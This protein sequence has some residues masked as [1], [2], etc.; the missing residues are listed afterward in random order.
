MADA[1][2]MPQMG[3][4]MNEGT[5]V[6]WLKHEGDNVAALGAIAEIETDKAVVEIEL[7][8]R[9]VVYSLL[10]QC[11][12]GGL[13]IGSEMKLAAIKVR[14]EVQGGKPVAG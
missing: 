11:S 13:K 1:V 8:E 3:Y 12:A 7:P 10:T 4:D 5:V 14:E 6:S 2:V 9:V